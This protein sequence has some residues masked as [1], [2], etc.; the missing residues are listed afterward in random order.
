MDGPNVNWAFFN[1][2]I[3]ESLANDGPGFLELGS[4]GLHVVHEAFNT[5]H[6]D[7]GWQLQ[8]ILAA[9]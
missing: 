5:G 8:R 6:S 1:L 9:A 2:M 3:E 4:C 7:A